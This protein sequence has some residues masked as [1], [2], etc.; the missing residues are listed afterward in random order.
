MDGVRKA[1]IVANDEYEDQG[2]RHLLAPAADA[3]A[4]A[5]VLGDAQI[6]GF[7]VR[8][9]RNEPAH[10]I[11]G[12]IE[13]LFS[14]SRPEDVLVLHFS[15]HGLK[16][17]SGELFFAARNTR[18]NRLASTAIP[19]DFV[20]R[21]MRESRS[22]RIVLLLDCCYGGAFSQGVSV[23]ASGDVNVLDSFPGGKM[24]GGRGRA[25]IT[26]SSAME[27]AF[28][29]DQLADDRSQQPSVFTSALVE[30]LATGDADRDQDGWISLNELYDYIFDRVRE[31]NPHQTPSRDMEMQGELYLARRSRPVSTPAPLPPELQEVLDHPLARIRA[32][33]VE[34]LARMLHGRH[35]GLALAAKLALEGLANDDSRMVAAAAAAALS[36]APRDEASATDGLPP[37]PQP[38]R[39][40]KDAPPAARLELSASVLDFGRLP[41]HGKPGQR[42][43]RLGNAGGGTL[44]AHATTREGWIQLRQR[45]DELL[46]SVR[47]TD[48]GEYQGDVNV[49]SN[50]GSATIRVLARVDPKPAPEEELTTPPR[51][52]PGGDGVQPTDDDAIPLPKPVDD[53]HRRR[54]WLV[55]AAGGTVTALI[56]GVVLLNGGT[57]TPSGSSGTTPST[58]APTTPKVQG[59][60]SWRPIADAALGGPGDQKMNAVTTT[61]K[62][63]PKY[64]AGGYTTSADGRDAAIWISQDGWKWQGVDDKDLG[65]PGDQVV[66]S[67]TPFVGGTLLA[68][69]SDSSKGDSDV[70]AWQSSDGRTWNR[71]GAS[72]LHE[73]GN[74][75]INRVNGT[76]AAGFETLADG[77]VDAVVW[78]YDGRRW[79]RVSD[80]HFRGPGRQVAWRALPFKS[81]SGTL[82]VAVGGSYGNASG[83]EDAAV[84]V[85]SDLRTWEPIMDRSLGG[86]GDQEITDIASFGT[87]LVA[88]G[89]DRRQGNTRG[90]AWLSDDGRTWRRSDDSALTG[91]GPDGTL[92]RVIP[93][94][95]DL[96][97][98]GAPKLIAGGYSGKAGALDAVIYSSQTGTTWA[99]E[100]VFS[101]DGDQ[102]VTSLRSVPDAVLAVGEVSS[103]HGTDAAVWVGSPRR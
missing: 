13:D 80:D 59:L 82:Y 36:A 37:S 71:V 34:E 65:G 47:T 74:Q 17:E 63:S 38:P 103:A 18:P 100:A 90:V 15:C 7:E 32:G 101:G 48:A 62:Q 57:S 89:F 97:K 9:V 56:I 22:R 86:V 44:H 102:Q 87:G 99:R 95:D 45:A 12:Q 53:Q 67:V 75:Q 27:Y 88:V 41:Q 72:Y 40:A 52:S 61:S 93:L 39:T 23:R 66:N 85:S 24:G 49:D 60:L 78:W 14:E 31:Q 64:L 19:A 54:W 35:A 84:W 5:G 42:T 43:V 55:G 6:G 20:Q 96:V 8:V 51:A 77:N 92:K 83:D 4:L 76:F 70:A 79:D 91:L 94:G 73:P 3:E 29:G 21:C 11:A 10:E 98:R 16:S 30:G 33:A 50:G 25:V 68:L 81:G 69:G 58:T 46:I 28:E 26:A 1:L 2:L